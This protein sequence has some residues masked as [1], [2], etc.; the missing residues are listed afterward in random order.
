MGEGETRSNPG[1]SGDR[2]GWQ[3]HTEPPSPTEN[4]HHLVPDS[5]RRTAARKRARQPENESPEQEGRA[6]GRAW[7]GRV[8]DRGHQ[9]AAAQG[10]RRAPGLFPERRGGRAGVPGGHPAWGRGRTEGAPAGRTGERSAPAAASPAAPTASGAERPGRDHHRPAPWTEA[11]VR[12]AAKAALSARGGEGRTGRTEGE[13]RGLRGGG[14]VGRRGGE[15]KARSCMCR[16]LLLPQ[17]A[18]CLWALELRG[19]VCV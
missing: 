9:R 1:P 4:K 6:E 17:A 8:R 12:G 15:W 13:R 5:G 2:Q 16:C 7:H 14:T 10:A 11:G 18:Q 3:T 19:L